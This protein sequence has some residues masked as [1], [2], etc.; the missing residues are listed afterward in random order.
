MSGYLGLVA[1]GAASLLSRPAPLII[2]TMVLQDYEVPSHITIGGSQAVTVHKLPGGGRIIDAMGPDD[3]V[4][5][6]HG[7]FVGL[8]AA[9]RA[10]NLDVMRIQG[11][12]QVLSF[13]DYTF[14][15]VVVHC[16]YDY[17][18]RGAIIKYRIRTE[19]VPNPSYLTTT[20]S[21]IDAALQ[22]DLNA[23]QTLITASAA[24]ASTYASL[25]GKADA[26]RLTASAYNLTTV[27]TGISSA[28][29]AAAATPSSS[30]DFG[31]DAQA[32]LQSV[33]MMLQD[34][35]HALSPPSTTSL[36]S[37]TTA[38]ALALA[39]A[40]AASLAALVQ[41]G[42]HVDRMRVNIASAGV[43]TAVPLVYA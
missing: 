29:A 1:G 37:L 23:S 31:E 21:D 9:Q 39:T 3:G 26:A 6:W 17:Q 36:E 30:F 25:V 12:P 35:I 34:S 27:A 10:R 18:E 4:V 32:D 7:L 19:I 43:Q 16:E 14:N 11:M 33:G 42:S 22:D 2:G 20:S 5:A 15:V 38:P 8:G 28:V 24:A 41:A 13:G 40:E